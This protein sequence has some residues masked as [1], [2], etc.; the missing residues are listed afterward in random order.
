MYTILIVLKCEIA[1]PSPYSRYRTRHTVPM[2]NN[3]KYAPQHM[4]LRAWP[5]IVV[6][7]RLLSFLLSTASPPPIAD[8]SSRPTLATKYRPWNPKNTRY[9]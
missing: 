4:P 1:G 6:R 7:Y 9:T 8:G 5:R 3:R 2:L